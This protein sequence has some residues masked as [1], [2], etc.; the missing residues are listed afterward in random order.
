M[1]DN[2]YS[3]RTSS[4]PSRRSHAP[5][6]LSSVLASCPQAYLATKRINCVINE[7]LET[8]VSYLASLR[9]V[10]ELSNRQ[11]G[12]RVF[13]EFLFAQTYSLGQMVET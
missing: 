2:Y 4:H 5:P 13:L 7:L 10:K 8:E 12:Y 3:N 6:L 9:E 11:F 1:L